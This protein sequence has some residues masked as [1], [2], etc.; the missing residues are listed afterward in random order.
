MIEKLLAR[1]IALAPRE[2]TMVLAASAVVLLAVVWLGLFEPAWKGREALQRELPE[3]RAQVA[4]MAGLAAVA[5]Q[6]GAQARAVPA[7]ETLRAALEASLRGA[8]LGPSIGQFEAT[9]DRISL[10][11]QSVSNSAWLAWLDE[12]LRETRMRVVDATVVREPKP[13]FV[14]VRVVLESSRREKR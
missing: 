7:P 9:G 10:K 2:R 13:G 14:S 6:A 12:V 11:L 5:Q 4:Q 8:G 3:L 1:W